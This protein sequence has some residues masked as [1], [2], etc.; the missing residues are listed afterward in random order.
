M[1]KKRKK[2]IVLGD[3]GYNPQNTVKMTSYSNTQGAGYTQFKF[4]KN[5][6]AISDPSTTEVMVKAP[7]NEM[8]GI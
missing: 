6:G 4:N 7:P 8:E 2:L 3:E 5:T 1:N